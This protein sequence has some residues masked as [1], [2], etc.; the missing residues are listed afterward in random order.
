MDNKPTPFKNIFTSV[1]KTDDERSASSCKKDSEETLRCK[2]SSGS[3]RYTY[4]SLYSIFR[5]RTFISSY[6]ELILT[7]RK[8][9]ATAQRK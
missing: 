1:S 2:L 8:M 4:M 6:D 9:I 3:G 5:A 7:E